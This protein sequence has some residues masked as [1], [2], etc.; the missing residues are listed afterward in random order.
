MTTNCWRKIGIWG[1]RSCPKLETQIHCRNCPVYSAAGR[2]LLEREAPAGYQQE[3]T[4]LLSKTKQ[5]ENAS[6]TSVSI[7]RLGREWLALAAPVFTQVTQPSPVHTLPH[8][9]NKILVGVVSIRGEIQICISL[10][11]LL[12]LETVAPER[13]VSPIIYKRMVMIEKEG[14]R[15]V[16]PADEIYGMHQIDQTNLENVP[17]TVSQATGTFTKAMINWQDKSVSY[18]DDELLFYTLNHRVL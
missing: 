3:W 17:A 9:S 1:D 16:F 6:I 7:F 12:E 18:L 15:W 2:T 10:S 14:S 13:S 8:R 4:S 5:E 11:A